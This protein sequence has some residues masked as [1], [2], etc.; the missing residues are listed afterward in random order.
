MAGAKI[1]DTIHDEIL[2]ESRSE[3]ARSTALVV[4]HTMIEAGEFYLRSV[5]VKVDVIVSDTVFF[6]H[7]KTFKMLVLSDFYLSNII[8]QI[9][10]EAPFYVA[11]NFGHFLN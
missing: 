6:D 7:L 4:E 10:R 1:I 2:V 9:R 8:G 3:T 5:P 11:R